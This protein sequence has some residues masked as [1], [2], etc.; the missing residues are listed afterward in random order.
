M[1]AAV[2]NHMW[3]S[4]EESGELWNRH[5]ARSLK[6]LALNNASLI[7]SPTFSGEITFGGAIIQ[8]RSAKS[9]SNHSTKR[10]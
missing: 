10:Y 1:M 4:R 6:A 2:I 5:S 9:F 8:S 3:G 7:Y